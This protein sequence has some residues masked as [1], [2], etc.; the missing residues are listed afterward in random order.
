M[1]AA[2]VTRGSRG[3][4][5]PE[6]TSFI[7]RRRELAEARRQM[8]SGR[9]LTLTGPA[10]VGKSRLALRLARKLRRAYPDGV[11][12]VGL[13]DVQDPALLPQTVAAALGG[14]P[15]PGNPAE[16]L[17][18][19]LRGERVLIILDDCDHVLGAAARLAR[20]LLTEHEHVHVLAT[21]RQALGVA[22]ELVLPVAPLSLPAETDA[23]DR[24]Y[25]DVFADAVSLFTDRAAAVVPGFRLDE[26]NRD[27]VVRICRRLDG[28]PLAI[29]LAA[30]QLG[31]STPEEVLDRLDDRF[32]LLT[33]GD[34]PARDEALEESIGWSFGL[35][36][37]G[38]QLLWARLSCF[39]GEWDA[40]AVREVCCDERLTA[41]DVDEALDV[42]VSKSVVV[43]EHDEMARTDYYRM[44]DSIREFGLSRLHDT[45]EEA[46][47]RARHAV[48]FHRLA[49]RYSNEVFGPRQLEWIHHMIHVHPN[50]RLVLEHDLADPER[51]R[52]AA[53]TAAKLWSF[54]FSGNALREG[55]EWL[56][57][58][59]A[60]V[61]EPVAERADCLSTLAFL[62]LHVGDLDAA[63]TALA[64]AV[65]IAERIG[66]RGLQARVDGTRGMVVM[67]RGRLD[68]AAGYLE[69]AAIGNTAT[70]NLFGY[71]NAMILLA[72]LGFYRHDPRGAESAAECLRLC[73]TFGA[74]WTKSYVL[75]VVSLHR[76]RGGDPREASLLIQQAIRLQ[77]LA[78]DLAGLGVYLEVL[79]WCA[80]STGQP[81]RAARL[82]G[83]SEAL[84]KANGGEMGDSVYFD[85]YDAV[86]MAW[87]WQV[88]GEEEFRAATREGAGWELPE[89]VAYALG[90][91]G[92]PP[93]VPFGA[94]VAELS[95]REVETAVLLAAGMT[96]AEIAERLGVE[97]LA[98]EV[99][100]E[101][102]LEQLGFAD[103]D[104]L[105]GWVRRRSA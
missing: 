85:D 61:P 29:E 58:S 16:G 56:R 75:W 28:M 73:E 40:A 52:V 22:G 59:V 50:L 31:E 57:S 100:A 65:E 60:A 68:E 64:E 71:T 34:Q 98:G 36:T 83:A 3:R 19:R 88:L 49:D 105:A 5:P 17:V 4:L 27:A 9:L 80:T 69:R 67:L 54:W 45:G 89:M 81:R 6:T 18:S 8:Y 104:E 94:G 2:D 26:G 43:R 93:E 90:E 23:P 95:P 21:S 91:G 92:S 38:E 55:Y 102:V 46:A 97:P 96:A 79:S 24:A 37:A 44:F 63:E 101:Q 25:G 74:P 1:E 20:E 30:A 53:A 62:A 48:C 51:A 41:A 76:W 72:C 32:A 87:A 84:R 42:L 15:G 11:V 86:A 13:S 14:R 7:G 12:L 103:R 35:C 33:S 77:Q 10:G 78:H 99:E 66:D 47:V 39:V 70:G 82:M